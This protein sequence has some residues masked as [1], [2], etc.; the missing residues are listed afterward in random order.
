[1]GGWIEIR[2]RG[3]GDCLFH[4]LA[5]GRRRHTNDIDAARALAWDI[6]AALAVRRAIADRISN[7]WYNMAANALFADITNKYDDIVN[8]DAEQQKQLRIAAARQRVQALEVLAGQRAAVDVGLFN[9]TAALDRTNGGGWPRCC[10]VAWLRFDANEFDGRDPT[11]DAVLLRQAY[12]LAANEI[13]GT[14]IWGETDFCMAHARAIY[15]DL[16]IGVYLRGAPLPA[17]PAGGHETSTFHVFHK[18]NHF[19]VIVWDPAAA[20]SQVSGLGGGSSLS[21]AELAAYQEEKPA[22]VTLAEAFR[23]AAVLKGAAVC[24]RCSIGLKLVNLKAMTLQS[25][26]CLYCEGRE[27]A[28]KGLA[29]AKEAEASSSKSADAKGVSGCSSDK[30]P[31]AKDKEQAEDES[32]AP[33]PATFVVRYRALGNLEYDMAKDPHDVGP[34]T[35][36][37][38]AALGTILGHL[39]GS[40]AIASAERNN[41]GRSV[42]VLAPGGTSDTPID[43]LP[44]AAWKKAKAA[45]VMALRTRVQLDEQ[46]T[47]RE[48]WALMEAIVASDRVLFFDSSTVLAA[49]TALLAPTASAMV[50]WM[51]VCAR[52]PGVTA[53]KARLDKKSVK[54][55]GKD[56]ATSEEVAEPSEADKL[57]GLIKDLVRSKALLGQSAVLPLRNGWLLDTWRGK[58]W[59]GPLLSH[60]ALELGA[61]ECDLSEI[62]NHSLSG[63]G[64]AWGSKKWQAY[65]DA[66]ASPLSSEDAKKDIYKAA[67]KKALPLRTICFGCLPERLGW[68]V[69]AVMRSPWVID[70]SIE[71]QVNSITPDSALSI[72]SWHNDNLGNLPAP[73]SPDSAATVPEW[74]AQAPVTFGYMPARESSSKSKIPAVADTPQ[75]RKTARYHAYVMLHKRI[76]A[77]AVKGAAKAS[78]KGVAEIEHKGYIEFTGTGPPYPS[79]VASEGSG[80]L[81]YEILGGGDRLVYDY[82]NHRMFLTPLHYA[83]ESNNP[84]LLITEVP[85]ERPF[86]TWPRWI[87]RRC[88]DGSRRDAQ[89]AVVR[90]KTA[91]NSQREVYELDNIYM[92][93]LQRLANELFAGSKEKKPLITALQAGEMSQITLNG[94]IV[95]SH[96]LLT[97]FFPAPPPDLKKKAAKAKVRTFT[98]YEIRTVADVFGTIAALGANGAGP[99]Q[100]CVLSWPDEQSIAILSDRDMYFYPLRISGA[101][102]DLRHLAVDYPSLRKATTSGDA[103]L[104][105]A[106]TGNGGAL[107]LTCTAANWIVENTRNHLQFPLMLLYAKK[108]ISPP[109]LLGEQELPVAD[110]GWSGRTSWGLGANPALEKEEGEEA[111]VPSS[112]TARM[113]FGMLT[114][115]FIDEEKELSAEF[116]RLVLEAWIVDEQ[117]EAWVYEHL[118]PIVREQLNRLLALDNEKEEAS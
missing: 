4:A 53:E 17:A 31:A 24:C 102:I 113:R 5:V 58:A 66:V 114:Q 67:G 96:K 78:S 43:Q 32:E 40:A 100:G 20:A 83:S 111:D 109:D 115:R 89:L 47:V 3:R 10:W 108:G 110:G 42:V 34:V 69:W 63:T 38:M 6:P 85:V 64:K 106:A 117:L 41:L 74:L 73:V 51:A 55:K 104:T 90:D 36:I 80:F 94:H 77:K 81:G 14:L 93:V 7:S 18:G 87:V 30:Q 84:F 56:T 46:A 88:L 59:L 97:D 44:I 61:A 45:V 16:T 79:T 54:A 23:S 92:R 62:A 13:F 33:V 22:N 72:R 29:K 99:T 70:S 60:L 21:L 27:Q 118:Q 12:A 95:A 105:M 116:Q 8:D 37:A 86:A 39:D 9:Q 71:A 52:A 91:A 2:V 26:L 35:N 65:I 1:M 15:H 48:L 50:H 75:S 107:P 28:K 25:C 82:L 112:Q 49:T 19:D 103:A 57:A 101:A 76:Q 68:M 98:M 11:G